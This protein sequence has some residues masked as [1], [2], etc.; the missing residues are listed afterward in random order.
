M[1][2]GYFLL[3]L[4]LR[5]LYACNIQ[6][7]ENDSLSVEKENF[8]NGKISIGAYIDTYFGYD[9]S[10][11][12]SGDRPYFVSSARH[13]EFTL[14]LAYI[15]AAYTGKRIRGVFKPAVGTYMAAN[16][17]A[18]PPMFRNL[19]EA[20]VGVKLFTSK[21]IWLDAGV[22]ISPFTN[23]GPVSMEQ[24]TYTRSFAG[25][26]VPYYISGL[27]LTTPLSNTLTAYFYLLNGWQNI[28][29][30]NRG[31]SGTLQLEYKPRENV[32]LN[33]NVY[34][35]NEQTQAAPHYGTRM[36]TD[37]FAVFNPDGKFFGTSSVYIGA[38]Q[39]KDTLSGIRSGTAYWYNANL[40]GRYKLLTDVSISGRLEYFYD[41]QSVQISPLT[42]I[43]GF[44]TFSSSLGIN[45]AVDEKVLLRAESRSFFSGKEVYLKKDGTPS[46][47]G[48]L[49]IASLAIAF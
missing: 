45:W 44:Q 5:V 38:Q 15:H 7:Q 40:I 48:Q 2:N 43:S 28:Q 21:D 27:K 26:Y 10:R 49:L 13:N 37:V 18:E 46:R 16:Y 1:K 29:E 36:F 41:P 23:E 42:G 47:T 11:P 34:V 3:A 14:N 24:L 9:F 20:N 8:T 12:A 6:A 25:E 33:W 17:A 32:T 4:T 22:F 30:N 35:G 39:R 31:K 19:L